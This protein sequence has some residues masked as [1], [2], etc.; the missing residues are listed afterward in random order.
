[1][2][3]LLKLYLQPPGLPKW[4]GTYAQNAVAAFFGPPFVSALPHPIA[5]SIASAAMDCGF[6]NV[7][8]FPGPGFAGMN[9][10]GAAGWMQLAK[11]SESKR[12]LLVNAF[13]A[14][15]TPTGPSVTTFPFTP[16]LEKSEKSNF[17]Y[18]LGMIYARYAL[19]QATSLQ[20][21]ALNVNRVLHFHTSATAPIQ[22]SGVAPPLMNAANPDFLIELSD[23]SWGLL[24][25]KGTLGVR[26]ASQ[27]KTAASQVSKY[28]QVNFSVGPA[29]PVVIPVKFT[30]IS[31]AY[32]QN[33][34]LQVEYLDPEEED[35]PIQ[36]VRLGRAEA[37]P[38]FMPAADCLRFLQACGHF[39]SQA[40][41]GGEAERYMHWTRFKDGLWLGVP[42]QM[43]NSFEKLSALMTLFEAVFGKGCV[44]SSATLIEGSS[45]DFEVTFTRMARTRL[46][47]L[48][49]DEVFIF[50]QHASRLLAQV[51]AS[52]DS[53]EAIRLGAFAKDVAHPKS[54]NGM[55]ESLNGLLH[56]L[57]KLSEAKLSD[58]PRRYIKL[59][60]NGLCI[61]D[62][63]G[64]RYLDV[65][66][67]SNTERF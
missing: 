1:M 19:E 56:S 49:D 33:G 21:G 47:R 63:A 39:A 10:A 3:S 48:A 34:D 44:N 25:A 6:G 62:D 15:I 2:A 30:A 67:P 58:Q 32:V 52:R 66:P 50:H 51:D 53:N 61:A 12:N 4:P 41:D 5:P 24:E 9:L 37:V 20:P 36:R 35:D 22:I 31:Y 7:L 65:D 45:V 13:D 29:A 14:A 28:A 18:F 11:Y 17:G 60:S 54:A 40:E 27:L 55:I 23:G 38:L 57:R 42:K 64:R 26:R 8:A 16:Q 59:L 43:W 46:Q